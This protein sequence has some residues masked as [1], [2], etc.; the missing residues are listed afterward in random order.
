MSNAHDY[1]VHEQRRDDTSRRFW[2]HLTEAHVD[3]NSRAFALLAKDGALLPS[4]L[5]PL[6]R[7]TAPSLR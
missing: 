5:V 4:H 7:G 2:K 1:A 3:T 6:I